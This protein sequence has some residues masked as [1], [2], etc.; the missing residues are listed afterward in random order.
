M[1]KTTSFSIQD[2]NLF[3][4]IWSFISFYFEK[5]LNDYPE[6]H[7]YFLEKGLSGLANALPHGYY[8]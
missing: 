5:L 7:T 6:K 1:T 3:L 8:I 4:L 2:C